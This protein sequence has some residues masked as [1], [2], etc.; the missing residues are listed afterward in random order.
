M[1]NIFLLI[2]DI[3]VLPITLLRLSLIYWW[4]SKYNIKG[5]KFLDVMLHANDPYFNI[6][7]NTVINTISDDMRVCVRDD[8]RLYPKDIKLFLENNKEF[9][10]QNKD[11]TIKK[12]SNNN[13][14]L[15]DELANLNLR[16][17]IFNTT[18]NKNYKNNIK[19]ESNNSYISENNS[20][21]S[22]D[23][24]ELDDSPNL[25][26]SISEKAHLRL[27]NEVDQFY[28]NIEN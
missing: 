8:S 1:E 9:I 6:N 3:C 16:K 18:E 5:L 12:E 2:F 13:R 23:N 14:E 11:E 22:S 24:N 28:K 4:G 21:K 15:D 10:L 20:N 17:N 25:T 26:V 19:S 7:N 27:E